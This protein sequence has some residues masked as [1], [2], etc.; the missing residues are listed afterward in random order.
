M[1]DG[2]FVDDDDRILYW[3]GEGPP[4]YVLDRPTAERVFKFNDSSL[5]FAPLSVVVILALL[6]AMLPVLVF[7]SVPTT[8]EIFTFLI[9]MISPKA[10][11]ISLV[12]VLVI[13]VLTF[14]FRTYGSHIRRG[15]R[16]LLAGCATIDMPRPAHVEVFRSGITPGKLCLVIFSALVA[17]L[18]FWAGIAL[19]SDPPGDR[20]LSI[21]LGAMFIVMALVVLW[22][23]R[24]DNKATVEVKARD[25]DQRGKP[26]LS[27]EASYGVLGFRPPPVAVRIDKPHRQPRWFTDEV[28]DWIVFPVLILV[29]LVGLLIWIKLR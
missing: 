25:G 1:Q 12:F 28:V 29:L 13:G 20:V 7:V 21:V 10:G 23:I 15:L 24:R 26:L 22:K 14:Y 16:P 3:P 9:G 19:T 27:E 4:G 6:F 5:S 2:F 8:E 11:V 17:L 18:L